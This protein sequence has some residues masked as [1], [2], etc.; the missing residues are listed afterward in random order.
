MCL[1]LTSLVRWY[2][3][4]F[5]TDS[6]YLDCSTTNHTSSLQLLKLSKSCK[7]SICRFAVQ[8]TLGTMVTS[9]LM[10]DCDALLQAVH[11]AA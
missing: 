4:I 1:R 2:V 11:F 3:Y 8:R 7:E 5:D 9:N 6:Q 10:L